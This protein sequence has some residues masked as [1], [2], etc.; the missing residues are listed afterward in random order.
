MTGKDVGAR[1]GLGRTPAPR[2]RGRVRVTRPMPSAGS[3]ETAP[4]SQ[5]YR[6]LPRIKWNTPPSARVGQADPGP[7]GPSVFDRLGLREAPPGL[8]ALRGFR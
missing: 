1:H 5:A 6:A 8:P 4:D 3:C 7:L 2:G